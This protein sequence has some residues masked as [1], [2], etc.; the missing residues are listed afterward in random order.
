[1]PNT[2]VGFFP[3]KMSLHKQCDLNYSKTKHYSEL[4]DKNGRLIC[5][6]SLFN[7]VSIHQYYS[8]IILHNNI[9]TIAKLVSLLIQGS[10]NVMVQWQPC[11]KNQ[12]SLHVL[13][14][15]KLFLKILYKV[16]LIQLKY[17]VIQFWEMVCIYF[18]V[19]Q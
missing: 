6:I 15:S 4:S 10:K 3:P 13:I 7:H 5:Y 17:L 11:Y 9:K 14:Y 1:M 8:G 2:Y 16:L 19:S 18:R 12:M